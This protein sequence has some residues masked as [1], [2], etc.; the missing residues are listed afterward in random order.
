LLPFQT[1]NKNL[2]LP[3]SKEKLPLIVVTGGSGGSHMVNAIILQILPELLEI[4]RVTHL[5][6]DA[7]SFGDFDTLYAKSKTLPKKLQ[8]RYF[9]TQFVSPE[10]INTL[11]ENADL[12]I[13]RS[14]INTV[15]AL[16]ILRKKAILI[17]LLVGQKDEQ[18]K[19]AKIMQSEGLA[20][21]L[22]QRTLSAKTLFATIKRMFEHQD[23]EKVKWHIPVV[24][25]GAENLMKEVLRCVS[26]PKEK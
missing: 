2:P 9:L 17:P 26:S 8:D 13:G 12:V 18:L 20:E 22:D 6:G 14:G 11:F 24:Q 7:R 19:N 15:A 23:S 16:L 3:V 1:R 25:N 4:A 5:T 10:D 21:I